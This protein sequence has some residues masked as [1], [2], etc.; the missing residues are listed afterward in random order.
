MKPYCRFTPSTALDVS[1][2]LKILVGY[3]CPFAIKSGG[4][5]NFAGA[6]NIEGGVTIDFGN[7]NQVT[8]SEDKRTASLGSGARWADVYTKLE[9]NGLAVV[10]GRI[11]DIGVGGLALGGGISFFS[12]RYGFACDNVL[13]Y[14]VRFA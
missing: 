7:L 9:K 12:G 11:G 1:L 8:L 14:E 13:N 2:T 3:Q 10:G 4:H 5:A 6:S